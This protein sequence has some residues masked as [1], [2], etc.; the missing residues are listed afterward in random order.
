VIALDTE[1]DSDGSVYII[2]F[3]DGIRHATF[4]GDDCRLAAWN[5]LLQQAPEIVWCC[6][7]EYDLINLF[8]P[9]LGKMCT[10][11]YVRSGLLRASLRDAP[12]VFYDS[13]RHWPMSVDNMGAYLNLPKLQSDFRSVDYCRRDTEIVWKF[14]AEMLTRYDK[15]GL[16]LRATLPSMALQLWK[17]TTSIDPKKI[18]RSLANYF[19][20]GYYGGR[21]EVYRF[22]D[23]HGRTNHYDINSLFPYVM[24]KYLYPDLSS[25]KSVATPDFS[26]EGMA[27]I[28]ILLPESQYPSLPVRSGDGMLYPYGGF[29]GTWTYPEIRKALLDGG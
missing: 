12:I 26:K 18:P 25:W 22:G 4:V 1:D 5:W 24:Q 11:Q 9:W 7:T 2:N 16:S 29:S 10:L 17:K 6:N 19:R 20:E 14:V 27:T 28:T 21:V 3:Y 15:L 23:I 13:L 8:G